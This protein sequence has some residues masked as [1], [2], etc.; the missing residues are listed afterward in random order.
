MEFDHGE[1]E[2]NAGQ[3]LKLEREI[4]SLSDR[5]GEAQEESRKI[6]D[7]MYFRLRDAEYLGTRPASRGAYVA[8]GR[9]WFV[10]CDSINKMEIE[11]RRPKE[12]PT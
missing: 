1:F 9:A 11:E 7:S 10:E 2:Q 12:E 5:L 8:R 6:K 4:Q 3:V